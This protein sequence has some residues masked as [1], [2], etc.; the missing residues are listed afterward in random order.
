VAGLDA[1]GGTFVDLPE[2]AELVLWSS[3]P[4]DETHHQNEYKVGAPVGAVRRAYPGEW[5]VA[6]HLPDISA[7]DFLTAICNTFALYMQVEDGELRLYPIRDLLRGAPQDWTSKAEPAAA[8][9]YDAQDGYAL[10]YDRQNDETTVPGQLQRKTDGGGELAIT[11]PFFSLY[12]RSRLV[13]YRGLQPD[14]QGNDYPYA[15]NG[16]TNVRGDQVGDWSLSWSGTGGLYETW[17]QEFVRLMVHGRTVT[18]LV[19]L[20]VADQLELRRWRHVRKYIY[21]EQGT[22]VGVIK[23]VKVKVS[24]AGIG[25]AEVEFQIEAN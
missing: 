19:R 3:R 14:L 24:T 11:T 6:D 23:R 9:A 7:M 16:R 17:W 4:L 5:N 2:A 8:I 22:A 10:D 21:S 13:F 20:S 15:T 12:V 1:A 18:R 25:V